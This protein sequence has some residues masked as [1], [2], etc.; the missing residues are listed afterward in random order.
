MSAVEIRGLAKSFGAK[1]VLQDIDLALAPGELLCLLGPTNA[2]KTT[3]L[4]TVAGLHRAD[5]G[6]V[7]IAGRDVTH[8]DPARRNVSLLFQNVALFPDRSGFENIAFPLRRSGLSDGAVKRRVQEV[9]ELLRI[10]HILDRL[11]ATFSGGEQQRTAIGRA[12]AHPAN[13]LL[14]DEPLS[15]LD[16]RIRGDLR[17]EFR[18]LHR[19]LGQTILYVTHDQ[20]EA[21]SLAD[22]IAVLNRGRLEQVDHVDTVYDRPA[23]RFVAEFI[24]APP[25]NLIPV[26]VSRDALLGDGFALDRPAAFAGV[27]LPNVLQIGIRPESV[28]VAAQRGEQTPIRA[29]LAW[30]EHHGPRDLIGARIGSDVIRAILPAGAGI[31]LGHSVWLGFDAAAEHLLDPAN[32]RFLSATTKDHD[33]VRPS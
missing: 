14:L 27:S 23:T 7:A 1:A 11:P 21:L 6:T 19:A 15:N 16:A 33:H 31:S 8:L 30:V 9:S 29:E 32:D 4:K 26:R 22:R 2:G 12:I 3:L 28:R 10:T 18:R 13:L 20:G 17:R 24:G 25:F 5:A